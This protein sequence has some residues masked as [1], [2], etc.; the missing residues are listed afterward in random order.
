MGLTARG[1]PDPQKGDRK[2]VAPRNGD[3]AAATPRTDDRKA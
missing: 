1:E 2:G 3:K